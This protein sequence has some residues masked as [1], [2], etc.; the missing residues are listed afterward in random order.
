LENFKLNKKLPQTEM[1]IA[2]FYIFYQRH[3]E[4]RISEKSKPNNSKFKIQN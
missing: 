4:R 3:P 2:A 1:F